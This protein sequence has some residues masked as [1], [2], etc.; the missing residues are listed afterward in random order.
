MPKPQPLTFEEFAERDP[1]P[2][3]DNFDLYFNPTGMAPH[4]RQTPQFLHLQAKES[5]L[6]SR[7]T[8]GITNRNKS[9]GKEEALKPLEPDMYKAYALMFQYLVEHGSTDPNGDLLIAPK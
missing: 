6:E 3:W 1:T 7:L 8:D 5:D 4:L 9:V 2:R